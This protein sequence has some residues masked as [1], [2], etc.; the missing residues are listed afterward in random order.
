[1]A[2]IFAFFISLLLSFVGPSPGWAQSDGGGS[3]TFRFLN[4][5]YH[6]EKF[7]QERITQAIRG[8]FDLSK[9]REVRIAVVNESGGTPYLLLQLLSR[10]YHRVDNARVDLNRSFDFL[11]VQK[12]YKMTPEDYI[13]QFKVDELQ[14]LENQFKAGEMEPLSSQPKGSEVK[15]LTEFHLR[16]SNLECPNQDVEFLTFAPND[17]PT[18][19]STAKEVA[20]EAAKHGLKS[21]SLLI[22][23]ATHDML[24]AF[25]KCPNL[26]GVFYDGD[27]NPSEITT[28]DGE[29]EASEFVRYFKFGKRVTHIWLACQAYND[30]MLSTMITSAEAQKYAAGINDLQIGSSDRTA[31]CAMKAALDGQPMTASFW[32]CYDTQDKPIDNW[33]DRWGFDGPGS[34]LFGHPP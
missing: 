1:M 14:P 2:R 11:G 28:N 15:A 25:L 10:K 3:T 34:D 5:N 29:L 17:E 30:P 6:G 18:E 13:N 21:V 23:D 16:L 20:A 8:N 31:A 4:S 26:K 9:Y 33:V 27:A 32:R 12:N 24:I 7:S 22:K 19:Q